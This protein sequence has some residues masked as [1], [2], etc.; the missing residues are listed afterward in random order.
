MGKKKTHKGVASNISSGAN[1]ASSSTTQ[2]ASKSSILQSSFCPSRFQLSLFA[3]VIQGLGSQHLRI[4][5]TST[6]R[7]Q[8]EH[9]IEPKASITCLDWGYYGRRNPQEPKRKRKRHDFENGDTSDDQSRDVVVALGTSVSDVL[10]FSPLEAKILGALKGGH[11]QG[12]RD[13]RFA[14]DGLQVE[15]WSIGGDGKLVQWDLKEG[16]VFRYSH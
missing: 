5:D 7:L 10:I 6:G 15:G 1:P 13:Y 14:Q 4:H 3:S 12:I 9:A 11:T 8:C 16:R 2:S